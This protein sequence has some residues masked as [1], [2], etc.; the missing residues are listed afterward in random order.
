[1]KAVRLKK[2]R[3]FIVRSEYLP[4]SLTGY[5]EAKIPLASVGPQDKKAVCA[6][7]GVFLFLIDEK[8]IRIL[9]ISSLSKGT[10]FHFFQHHRPW[11]KRRFQAAFIC[12]LEIAV[13]PAHKGILKRHNPIIR[14]RS[15][16]RGL[17]DKLEVI[18]WKRKM[19]RFLYQTDSRRIQRRIQLILM[20]RR[21]KRL[22][23]P[24]YA[25]R[26]LQDRYDFFI[27]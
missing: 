6:A 4:L 2:I 10:A 25:V 17:R 26:P 27:T 16:I 21:A 3:F 22:S 14:T 5:D 20:L 23:F 12:L 18:L 15:S 1:M 8:F 9:Y 19:I 13:R 24:I 11:H 7:N